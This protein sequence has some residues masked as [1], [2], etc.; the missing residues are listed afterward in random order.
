MMIGVPLVLVVG[1]NGIV[2][3]GLAAICRQLGWT[4][5]VA[6]SHAAALTVLQT[7]SPTAVVL[8]VGPPAVEALALVRD[9][10]QILS[11]SGSIIVVSTES[12]HAGLMPMVAA[13]VPKGNP[14]HFVEAL[15]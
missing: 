10:Y 12:A 13:W 8:D 5:H 4:V 2:T 6:A 9:C 1:P 15:Q 11:G 3:S 7:E 14:D